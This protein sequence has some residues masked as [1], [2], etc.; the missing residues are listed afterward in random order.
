MQIV[1]TLECDIQ[2]CP[3]KSSGE[4]AQRKQAPSSE[5]KAPGRKLMRRAT[6][7]IITFQHKGVLTVSIISASNL[8]VRPP[9]SHRAG[10]LALAPESLTHSYC[11]CVWVLAQKDS[12]MS[13]RQEMLHL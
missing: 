5:Q 11:L 4:A 3:F 13:R 12:T 6:K 10:A 7:S 2:Y 9:A 8:T 1:A